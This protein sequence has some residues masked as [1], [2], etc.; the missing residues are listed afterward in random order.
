[1]APS[2]TPERS[3]TRGLWV[4]LGV[5]LGVVVSV[6]ALVFAIA[7]IPLFLFAQVAPDGRDRPEVR[8]ALIVSIYIGAAIGIVVGVAVGVWAGRGG[9]LPTD[10]TPFLQVDDPS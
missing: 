9:R 6:A 2:P 5:G 10:R 7:A 1:V 8:T 3:P 4:G